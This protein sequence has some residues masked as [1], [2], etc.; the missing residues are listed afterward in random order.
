M[1]SVGVIRVKC[2]ACKEIIKGKYIHFSDGSI[3]CNE[4]FHYLPKCI[5]CT[6][7]I[8]GGEDSSIDGF[9]TTCYKRA[10][11]CDICEKAII[12]S[13]TRFADKSISCDDCMKK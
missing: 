7:P 2:D 4:C 11:K 9:C 5:S 1:V 6:K 8:I 10:P 12:G 3:F 13:Y